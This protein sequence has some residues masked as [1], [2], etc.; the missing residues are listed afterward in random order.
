MP[1][2]VHM[3]L[4]PLR[5]AQPGAAVPHEQTAYFTF[6]EI[7]GGIKGASAHAINRLLGRSGAVWQDESF[8]HVLRSTESLIEKTEYLSQNLV[9]K[10]LVAVPEDYP[11]LW[12]AGSFRA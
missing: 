2:R 10:G 5:T 1:D 6:E 11:C 12:R 7:L 3:T 4:T 9:R 8:D